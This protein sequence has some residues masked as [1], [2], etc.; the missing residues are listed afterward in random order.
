MK[1]KKYMKEGQKLPLFGMTYHEFGTENK[2]VVLLIHPAVV[3]WDYFE[4]VIPLLEKDFHLIIPAL[5]GYDPDQKEDF[6]SIEEIA[7]A[8]ERW[9][10]KKKYRKWNAYMAVPWAE[11]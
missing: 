7:A 10:K 6:T 5:P 9:F 4:Y 2:R 1:L 3:M 8:I 11:Q